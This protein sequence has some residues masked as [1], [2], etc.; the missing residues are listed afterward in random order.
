MCVYRERTGSEDSSGTVN[1]ATP[2]KFIEV[3]E[4][5]SS[6]PKFSVLYAGSSRTVSNHRSPEVERR[7]ERGR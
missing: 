3:A 4:H 7:K 2:F 5:L 6:Q 1:L